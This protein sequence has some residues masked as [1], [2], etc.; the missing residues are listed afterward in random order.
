[1][2]KILIIEL[3]QSVQLLQFYWVFDF[4]EIYTS[5]SAPAAET[6]LLSEKESFLFWN[7]TA[8]WLLDSGNNLTKTKYSVPLGKQKESKLFISYISKP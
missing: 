8:W 2:M 6:G 7:V 1:M 4:A 3:V 5:L